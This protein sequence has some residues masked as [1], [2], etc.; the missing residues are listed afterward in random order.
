MEKE[1]MMR[2]NQ[3]QHSIDVNDDFYD[4][5][6]TFFFGLSLFLSFS[7]SFLSFY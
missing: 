5:M 2:D 4:V 7:F 6:K 3:M 1:K